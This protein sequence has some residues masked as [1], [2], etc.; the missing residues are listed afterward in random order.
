MHFLDEIPVRQGFGH[1]CHKC[2]GINSIWSARVIEFVDPYSRKAVNKSTID[3][4]VR[5][6]LPRDHTATL[7][8]VVV[9]DDKSIVVVVSNDV[10]KG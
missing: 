4:V 3:F 7:L 1:Y 2:F 8:L 6:W 10:T 5:T 9:G